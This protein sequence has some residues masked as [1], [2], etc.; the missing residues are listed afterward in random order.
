MREIKIRYIF[1]NRWSKKLRQ[2]II[3]IEDL[4]SG[5][6]S[7]G[8]MNKLVSKDLFAGFYDQRGNE[9]YEG[10]IVYSVTYIEGVDLLGWIEFNE[11]RGTYSV[12]L[13]PDTHPMTDINASQ[14]KYFVKKGNVY[15]DSELILNVKK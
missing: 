2:Q 15:E 5:G 14:M 9:L 13:G 7:H 12:N 4:E 3:T 1:Q 8:W 6:L 10:D 11:E